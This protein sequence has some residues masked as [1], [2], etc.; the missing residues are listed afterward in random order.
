MNILHVITTLDVGGAEMHLL[1]QVKGQ[2]AR[3]HAV[4]VVWLKGEGA[5]RRD[6]E[7][8]GALGVEC[9]GAGIRAPFRLARALRG[10]DVVHTHLLKADMLGACVALVTGRGRRLVASKHN[11]EQVLKRPLA[12]FVHGWLG[13]VPRRTIVLSD[14]V[15]RFVARFGRVNP[16]R[17]TRIYYGLDPGPF[18]EAVRAARAPAG[19]PGVAPRDALRRSL[20]FERD[21]VVFTCVARF[22]PQK[23]H[24]VLLEALSAVRADTPRAKL[25]LVGDDPFGDGRRKAEALAQELG[26]GEACV[27]AG[28]RRDI[29][30]ILAA[31]DVFVMCSSWEGFG[32]VFLEAMASSLPV[33]A[34]RVSAVPEVVLERVTGVLVDPANPSMLAA[35]MRELAADPALRARL[36]AAGNGRVRAAFGLER[37]I[38]ETLRVYGDADQPARG[39]DRLQFRGGGGR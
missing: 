35:G 1:A 7:V 23:A 16:G 27:F 20:G 25:L 5:L 37:M 13:N 11:D 14:H 17:I 9:I 3:G 34:T 31:S 30:Q 22:A 32:L 26:L 38:E 24:D 6:F 19:D 21:D 36:G 39:A 10:V 29:P 18:E 8:A 15:A 4:R 28:I 12:S 2:V 33:L